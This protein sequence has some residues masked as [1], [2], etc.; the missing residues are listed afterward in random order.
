[1]DNFVKWMFV[2][3]VYPNWQCYWEYFIFRDWWTSVKNVPSEELMPKAVHCYDLIFAIISL[4]KTTGVHYPQFHIS[5]VDNYKSEVIFNKELL[6][7]CFLACSSDLF[8]MFCVCVGIC[9][10]PPL[11]QFPSMQI[12]ALHSDLILSFPSYCTSSAEKLSKHAEEKSCEGNGKCSPRVLPFDWKI[13]GLW[14][15]AA[16]TFELDLL[17]EHSIMFNK[18]ADPTLGPLK[19]HSPGSAKRVIPTIIVGISVTQCDNH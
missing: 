1:M 3:T 11:S 14:A 4:K 12:Y 17:M 19:R 2:I 13:K 10:Q 9:I 18:Q 15:P 16:W 8:T 5:M 6:I 7:L